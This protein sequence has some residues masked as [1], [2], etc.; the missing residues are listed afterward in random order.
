MF[1]HSGLFCKFA[2]SRLEK[3]AIFS[4]GSYS[5]SKNDCAVRMIEIETVK[6]EQIAKWYECG[7]GYS[8]KHKRNDKKGKEWKK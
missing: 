3:D 2:I 5:E 7:M 6:K 1:F 8:N 4:V